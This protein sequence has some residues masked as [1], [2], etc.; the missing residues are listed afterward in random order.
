MKEKIFLNCTACIGDEFIIEAVDALGDGGKARKKPKA[1]ALYL[2][3]AVLAL[4][5]LAA[6]TVIV[7][8]H[9]KKGWQT[10][11]TVEDDGWKI[12]Y[13]SGISSELLLKVD[14]PEESGDVIPT[15]YD[16]YGEI[17]QILGASLLQMDQDL[18][19][20]GSIKASALPDDLH[21]HSEYFPKAKNAFFAEDDV[22]GIFMN[23][24]ITPENGGSV[25]L[26]GHDGTDEFVY[27]NSPENGLEAQIR[28]S[29]SV[30]G[31]YIS[32]ARFAHNGIFYELV[33]FFGE[34]VSYDS[35]IS[36][37]KKCIDHLK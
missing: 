6:G 11:F 22:N 34:S 15:I 31:H 25:G 8:G 18:F 23:I 24:T 30:Y 36:I 5:V 37:A 32:H 9:L 29:M 1:T 17:E 14:R 2:I 20:T 4:I 19:E 21:L 10:K 3:A 28:C 35:G 12:N 33:I 7:S 16:N 27:Y 26:G 13:N